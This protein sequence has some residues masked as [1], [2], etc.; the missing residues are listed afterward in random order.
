MIII[1]NKDKQKE[2]KESRIIDAHHLMTAYIK[3]M[4]D[5]VKIKELELKTD[6]KFI[7]EG[8][9]RKETAVLR[10]KDTKKKD[11]IYSYEYEFAGHKFSKTYV[12]NEYR[13]AKVL[14][15]ALNHTDLYKVIEKEIP[16][17]PSLK[18]IWEKGI[19]SGSE[20]FYTFFYLTDPT[21]FKHTVYQIGNTVIR[22]KYNLMAEM[23]IKALKFDKDKTIRYKLNTDKMTLNLYASKTR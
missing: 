15:L 11:M 8:K 18:D 10:F 12:K 13:N 22:D 19:N 6:V 3:N 17:N 20:P 23:F 7:F 16:A 1:L 5:D 4:G 21:L 9:E 14:T 2:F